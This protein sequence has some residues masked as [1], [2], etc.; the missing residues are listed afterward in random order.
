MNNKNKLVFTGVSVLL[1]LF[2][3]SHMLHVQN[4]LLPFPLPD[5]NI[6]TAEWIL[7]DIWQA[8]RQLAITINLLLFSPFY[9]FVSIQL[10]K[11][12]SYI[13]DRIK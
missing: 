6:E 7:K 12:V 11:T 3:N 1:M 8:R 5:H 2:V 13:L 4:I 9:L 10:L